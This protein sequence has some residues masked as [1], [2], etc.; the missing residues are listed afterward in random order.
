[1]P[2]TIFNTLIPY[3]LRQVSQ[4]DPDII[5]MARFPDQ[6]ALRILRLFPRLELQSGHYVHQEF[7]TGS[8][9]RTLFLTLLWPSV[10][11]AEPSPQLLM[12]GLHSQPFRC[13]QRHWML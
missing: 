7:Y 5:D 9:I 3:S 4:S 11:T 8:G 12:R 10:L 6:L 2:S 1:M 13:Q